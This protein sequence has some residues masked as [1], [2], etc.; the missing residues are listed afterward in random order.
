M[1]SIEKA[2]SSSTELQAYLVSCFIYLVKPLP[3]TNSIIQTNN[4]LDHKL[5]R[6]SD[7]LK[8]SKINVDG[9]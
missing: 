8:F 7:S 5:S 1:S 2:L 4:F 9:L 3:V 6:L